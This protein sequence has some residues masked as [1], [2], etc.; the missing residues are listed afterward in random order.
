MDFVKALKKVSAPYRYEANVDISASV[1]ALDSSL[2]NTT[3][4]VL[5]SALDE[6]ISV[7]H[8]GYD[9]VE[10]KVYIEFVGLDVDGKGGDG[11]APA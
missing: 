4:T 9:L 11:E 7:R 3:E 2:L 10:V 5:R 6:L 1:S 8:R